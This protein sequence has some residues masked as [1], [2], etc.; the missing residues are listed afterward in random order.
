MPTSRRRRCWSIRNSSRSGRTSRPSARQGTTGRGRQGEGRG[1]LRG[2][3]P[4]HRRTPGPARP[5]AGRNRAGQQHHR[6]A[7]GGEPRD[8][9]ARPRAIP[10]QEAQMME[11]FRNYPPADER[12]ARP[13]LRG[14]GRRFRAGA[15]EGDRSDGDPGRTGP[16]AGSRE[17]QRRISGRRPRPS[18]LAPVRSRREAGAG[19]TPAAGE[20]R[21]K[22]LW[23]RRGSADGRGAHRRIRQ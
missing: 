20:A 21:L 14:Q 23:P 7:G 12:P 15:G 19:E 2:R 1:Q 22:R 3:L 10:G 17:A 4:R 9:G 5:A 16:G 8:A 13:D 6:H 11:F 18:R